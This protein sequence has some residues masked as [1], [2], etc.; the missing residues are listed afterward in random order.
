M[1]RLPA[2]ALALLLPLVLLGC[3]SGGSGG[4]VVD[5]WGGPGREAGNFVK[6][7]GLAVDLARNAV[8]VVD[9][10]SRLQKFTLD[11]NFLGSVQLPD[12]KLGTGEGLAITANGDLLLADT[13]YH[14]VLRYNGE[15]DLVARF[16]RPGRKPGE[17]LFPTC[18]AV[19][20]EG[21]IFVAGYGDNRVQK[22]DSRGKYL[23]VTWGS[24]GGAPGQFQRPSG[25]AFDLEGNLLVADASNHR[26]QRFTPEG[27][28][29][30]SWGRKGTAAGEL[31]YPYDLTVLP[32]GSV[33]VAENY[34]NRL[35]RFSLEG[36]SLGVFGSPGRELGS[37]SRPWCLAGVADGRIFVSDTLNHR[38]QVV[39]LNGVK[40]PEPGA[41]P[42]VA[43]TGKKGK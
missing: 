22:F 35:Q 11:G 29:L 8:Y 23:G 17:L 2:A 43:S 31:H 18:V 42:V 24:L 15:L 21:D 10:S 39:R 30:G 7:R 1:K 38:V 14:R 3:S 13:H 40:I 41:A 5:D 34:N 28:L 26:V 33:L 6:P 25:I 16:G 32:D 27:K 20:A 36:E 4:K 9:M 37:F 12:S 19:D